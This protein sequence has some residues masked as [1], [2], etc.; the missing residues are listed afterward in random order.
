MLYDELKLLL[1]L[2]EKY[3]KSAYPEDTG[4][5]EESDLNSVIS[6]IKFTLEYTDSIGEDDEN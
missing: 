3:R 5:S 6:S 4:T 1:E 2:L